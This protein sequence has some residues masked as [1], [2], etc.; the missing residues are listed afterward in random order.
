MKAFRFDPYPS[1]N[2]M[3]LLAGMLNLATRTVINWFHNHRMR[4]RYKNTSSA[5]STPSN[6]LQNHQ[7]SPQQQQQG[8][9]SSNN[10]FN[11]EHYNNLSELKYSSINNTPTPTTTTLYGQKTKYNNNF[12]SDEYNDVAMSVDEMMDDIDGYDYNIDNDTSTIT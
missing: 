11:L 10:K 7:L 5:S 4:I 8:H 12:N 2:Q 6:N 9:Q 3:E 1:V